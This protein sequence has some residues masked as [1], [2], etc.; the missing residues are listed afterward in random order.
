MEALVEGEVLEEVFKEIG[1]S[2]IQKT[3]ELPKSKRINRINE[4]RKS[5][6]A[7][8]KMEDQIS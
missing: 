4:T 6:A 5:D 2:A 1:A 3:H 8:M 7:I